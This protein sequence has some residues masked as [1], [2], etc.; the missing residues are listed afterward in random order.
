MLFLKDAYNQLHSDAIGFHGRSC[1]CACH[2][3]KSFVHGG[4]CAAS[5]HSLTGIT[6]LWELCVCTK[7]QDSAFHEY[8]CLMGQ[9]DKFGVKNIP[10]CPCEQQET[11]RTIAVQVFED[12]QVQNKHGQIG[13]QKVLSIKQLVVGEFTKFLQDQT[14]SFIKHNFTYRWQDDQYRE[15]LKVFPADT[16]ISVVDFVKNYSFKEKNEIQSMHWHTDQCTILVPISYRRGSVD[17][18]KT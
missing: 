14:K 1:T 6:K 5:E 16:I 18:N 12:V 9:C 4:K 13:K 11:T 10:F 2:I 7:N 8:K 17:D 15:C 3:C